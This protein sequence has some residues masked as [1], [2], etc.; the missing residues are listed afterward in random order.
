MLQYL[1][2]FTLSIEDLRSRPGLTQVWPQGLVHSPPGPGPTKLGLVH[3]LT[4]P[5]PWTYGVGPDQTQVCE[6]QDQ[7][8]DSLAVV[9]LGTSMSSVSKLRWVVRES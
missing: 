1:L 8:P 3:P 9:T 5:D 4:G 2:I 6:G 7:T